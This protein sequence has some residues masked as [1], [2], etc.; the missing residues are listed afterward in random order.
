MATAGWPLRGSR[1]TKNEKI[2]KKKR[3]FFFKFIHN[4]YASFPI[5]CVSVTEEKSAGWAGKIVASYITKRLSQDVIQVPTAL[6]INK[7]QG[8]FLHFV[9]RKKLKIIT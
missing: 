3:N 6:H 8:Q 2:Q 5:F 9:A 4:K 7:V 1:G